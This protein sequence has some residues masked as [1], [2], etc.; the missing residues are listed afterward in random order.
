MFI[1][2]TSAVI[3]ENPIAIGMH[4][5]PQHSGAVSGLEF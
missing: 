3:K 1:A 5:H 4:N 2:S